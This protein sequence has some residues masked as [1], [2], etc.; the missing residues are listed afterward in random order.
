VKT[1]L[2]ELWHFKIGPEDD[3][4][5]DGDNK[6]IGIY[7]SE[8]NA[9]AAIERLKSK[10]GFRDWPG[11]FRIFD[12]WLDHDGWTEGFVNPYDEEEDAR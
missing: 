8:A 6:I 5:E 4:D 10:P 7:S 3:F 1:T 12:C 11:G 2:Y 9:K